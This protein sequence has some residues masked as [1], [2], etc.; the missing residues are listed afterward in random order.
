MYSRW[1]YFYYLLAIMLLCTHL[2]MWFM[3]NIHV[4][5]HHHL[6]CFIHTFYC[7]CTLNF[8]SST[9]LDMFV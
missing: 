4:V 7:S 2:Q 8:H 9:M 5:H 1:L 3:L 6:S